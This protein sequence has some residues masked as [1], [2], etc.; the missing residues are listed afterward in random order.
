MLTIAAGSESTSRES[1]LLQLDVLY[2]MMEQVN[3]NTENKVSLMQGVKLFIDDR[4]TQKKG[5][6]LLSRIIQRF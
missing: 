2:A 4:Q 5:Y 6:K 1:V 3:L